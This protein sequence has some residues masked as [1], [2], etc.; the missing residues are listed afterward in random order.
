MIKVCVHHPLNPE[1]SKKCMG[2]HHHPKNW[3]TY[4]ELPFSKD[5]SVF[6]GALRNMAR[7]GDISDSDV[8]KL[9]DETKTKFDGD[10]YSQIFAA[11]TGPILSSPIISDLGGRT[12]RPNHLDLNDPRI[13]EINIKY[14]D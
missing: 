1:K 10:L 7:D 6:E 9:F 14:R 8:E 11:H 12:V 3:T 4:T 5:V 13:A 2:F